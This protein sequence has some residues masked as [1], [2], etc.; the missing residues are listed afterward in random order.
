MKIE[1]AIA[2]LIKEKNNGTQ[3]IILAYWKADM[4]DQED[5]DEWHSYTELVEDEMDWSRAHDQMTDLISTAADGFRGCDR[6]PLLHVVADGT[7]K[8]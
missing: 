3:S 7:Q 5:N 2:Q 6:F 8:D 1:D 4:F